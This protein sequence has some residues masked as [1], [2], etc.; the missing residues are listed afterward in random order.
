M[1]IAN[2]SRKVAM[3]ITLKIATLFVMMLTVTVFA[4]GSAMG[5][6]MTPTKAEY[7]AD[8]IMETQ[9]MS[10]TSRIFHAE[11]KDRMEMNVQG[12]N[13]IMINRMDKKL[14]WVLMPD[15]KA[16][17]ETSL[18]EGKKKSNDINSCKIDQKP[19]GSESVNGIKATRNSIAMSCPDGLK[20]TGSLWITHEGI[21]VKLDSVAKTEKGDVPFKME[22]KNLKIAR[23]DP[24][25][26]EIPAGYQVFSMGGLMGSFGDLMNKAAREEAQRAR[27]EEQRARDQAARK[28]QEEGRSYTA[29][30]REE[31]RSYT[32]K[33]RG[34]GRSYSAEPREAGRSYTAQKRGLLDGM[35]DPVK[36][37]KGILSW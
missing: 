17:M 11:N 29:Q 1:R 35:I 3:K 18:E 9:G 13:S 26:F 24:R 8:S 22:L 21:M 10:V 32:S 2:V 27:E 7:S 30:P 33:P 19:L 4:V 14:A 20:Y 31:G 16:Y 36:V 37:L 28:Q 34:E 12:T 23:Q 15:Q 5:A 6:A 25:L